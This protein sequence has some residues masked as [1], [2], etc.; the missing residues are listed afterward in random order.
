MVTSTGNSVHDTATYSCDMNFELVGSTT[1]TCT[2]VDV[3]SAIFSPVPPVCR[4]K[5][6]I[7]VIGIYTLPSRKIRR[8][9]IIHCQV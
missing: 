8:W 6:S 7:H 4:R 5:W 9:Y 2:Q 3:N 1:V